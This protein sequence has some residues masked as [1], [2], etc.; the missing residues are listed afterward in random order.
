MDFKPISNSELERTLRTLV[1]SFWSSTKHDYFPGPLP[2]SIERIN[3]FK[4]KKYPYLIC[5]KSDGIRYFLLIYQGN[6]YIIDRTFKIYEINLSLN[7]DCKTCLFDGELVI[8]ESGNQKYIIH[9]CI[10]FEDINVIQD[11]FDERYPCIKTFLSNYYNE[12][13][14]SK[15]GSQ[16]GSIGATRP[17]SLE[18]FVLPSFKLAIKKFFKSNQLI[19]FKKY[20]EKI[21]HKIDG[22]IFTPINLPIGTGTQYSLFK[23]KPVHTFDFLICDT[24]DEIVAFESRGTELNKFLSVGKLSPEGRI[25]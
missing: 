17:D 19:E 3:L 25:F 8:G 12:G 14:N 7:S 18:P 6:S 20:L 24:E 5:A 10:C 23:W 11:N 13:G 4:L 1:L 22:Y 15:T 16:K 21:D 2:V 9:D